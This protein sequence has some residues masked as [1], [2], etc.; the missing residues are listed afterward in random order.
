MAQLESS[1]EEQKQHYRELRS[2]L[3]RLCH[4]EVADYEHQKKKAPIT[5]LVC[6]SWKLEEEF[7]PRRL[8]SFL[9]GWQGAALL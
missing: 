1:I 5:G 3:L 8:P 4:E 2:E 6:L 9:S 7:D